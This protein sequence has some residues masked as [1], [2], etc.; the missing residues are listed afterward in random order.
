MRSVAAAWVWCVLF[1]ALATAPHAAAQTRSI[2]D[3]PGAGGRP[4]RALIT[5]GDE[6]PETDPGDPAMLLALR[7]VLGEL[8]GTE[9]NRLRATSPPAP[10]LGD[11]ADAE[12]VCTVHLIGKKDTAR[13]A[14]YRKNAVY[15][16]VEMDQPDPRRVELRGPEFVQLLAGLGQYRGPFAAPADLMR[17]KSFELDKP[18]EPGWFFLD[19][20]TVDARILNGHVGKMEGTE[21]KLEDEHLWVR[22]PKGYNPRRPAGLLVWINAGDTGAIPEPFAGALDELGFIAIGAADSGNGRSLVA[23]IQL[24]LDAL[25]TASRR[26]HIDPRRVYTTGIS[27]GGRVCSIVAGCWPD[28]FTGCIPIVGLSCYENVPNGTGFYYPAAFV[29][30][31]GDRFKFLRTRRWAPMTGRKDANELEMQQ[32]TAIFER[33]GMQIRLFDDEKMGHQLPAAKDLREAML[34]VDEPYHRLRKAE[35]DAAAAALAEYTS[36]VGDR[37]PAIPVERKLLIKVVEAGPWTEA[38]WKAS[39]LLGVVPRDAAP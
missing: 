3:L 33:D 18:Y 14:V 15:V 37:A 5:I 9:L 26:F 39:A 4:V 38:A 20:K 35:E 12:R 34:W 17:E 23:R 7:G 32:A 19:K 2:W 13:V 24:A 27:G 36:K 1:I 31:G 28:Y 30:P 21:R 29:R 22:I 25:A 10:R 8:Q 6:R 11:A 16:A